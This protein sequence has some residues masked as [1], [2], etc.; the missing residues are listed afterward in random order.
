SYFSTFEI[1]LLRGRVFTEQD[2]RGAPGVVIINQAM[3]RRYWL[4]GDPLKDR[5]RIGGGG[6]A[7]GEPARQ[8][9]GVVGDTHDAGVDL[10]PFPTMYTPIAQMPDAETAL[11]SKVVP[12][13]WIVRSRMNP[14]ALR[15]PIEAALGEASGDLPIAQVRTMAEVESRKTARQ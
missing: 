2:D 6:P 10:D 15:T 4:N 14:Y 5:I 1:P 12:L 11:N 13:R 3:A 8:I 7:L 9:V